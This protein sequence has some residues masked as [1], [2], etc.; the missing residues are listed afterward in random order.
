MQ[1][2]KFGDRAVSGLKHF[3][4]DQFGNRLHVL[5]RQPVKEPV[6]QLPPCPKAVARVGATGFGQARHRALKCMAMQVGGRRQKHV[7]RMRPLGWP[8]AE[9]RDAAIVKGHAQIADPALGRKRLFRMNF[10]H[11][12][13]P[14]TK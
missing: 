5:G 13:H 2:M 6:H 1:V 3:H 11:R 14:L 10:L 4:E 8:G 9:S 12:P 7:H